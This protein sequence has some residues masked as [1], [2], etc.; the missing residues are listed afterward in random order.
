MRWTDTVHGQWL[1][2]RSENCGNLFQTA[3]IPFAYF[4]GCCVDSDDGTGSFLYR[5]ALGKRQWPPLRIP[6]S[7]DILSQQTVL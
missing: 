5:K 7:N 1:V 3:K 4:T 6:Y 2:G